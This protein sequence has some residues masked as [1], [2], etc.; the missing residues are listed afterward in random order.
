MVVDLNC[1]RDVMIL[2]FANVEEHMEPYIKR[3][4]KLT[5]VVLVSE[6]LVWTVSVFLSFVC[7]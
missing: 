5:V 7:N 2:L 6:D 4:L 1:L 3:S